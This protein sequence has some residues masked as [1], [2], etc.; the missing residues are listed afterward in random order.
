ML[1]VKVKLSVDDIIEALDDLDQGEKDRLQIA[2]LNLQYDNELLDA[3]EEAKEDARTGRVEPHDEV[4]K[5]IR[6]KY[7]R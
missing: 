5:E 1:T 2:L 6:A 3:L 4:M 7:Y